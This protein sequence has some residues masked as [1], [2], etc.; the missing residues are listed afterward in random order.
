MI[1]LESSFFPT[2]LLVGKFSCFV[3]K[4]VPIG[5]VCQNDRSKTIEKLS[6]EVEFLEDQLFLLRRLLLETNKVNMPADAE[7]R[8]LARLGN[9]L[10]GNL[11][12]LS[13]TIN[14]ALHDVTDFVDKWECAVHYKQDRRRNTIFS[15]ATYQSTIE[16]LLAT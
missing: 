1:Y 9:M 4:L 11:W 12:M 13:N 5:S 15:A 2:Q 7:N 6:Q 3:D 10:E 8:K 14:T 16:E